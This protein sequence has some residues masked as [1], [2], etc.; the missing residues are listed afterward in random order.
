MAAVSRYD[1][2]FFRI[3]SDFFLSFLPKMIAGKEPKRYLPCSR[4]TMEL[5]QPKGNDREKRYKKREPW[6]GSKSPYKILYMFQF[7]NN[8]ICP[9][10]D[11]LVCPLTTVFP[12]YFLS[13]I[14]AWS[15]VDHG[16]YTVFYCF[17]LFQSHFTKIF[18]VL[19]R[20][21]FICYNVL[22]RLPYTVGGQSFLRGTVTSV[23]IE[24][25]YWKSTKGGHTYDGL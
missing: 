22:P 13:A 19:L 1:R 14:A 3:F 6:T 8:F 5:S 18:L 16:I 17:C 10:Q 12:V 21:N 7:Q 9:F 4:R 15:A 23:Y 20:L 24:I 25:Q 2:F 11:N